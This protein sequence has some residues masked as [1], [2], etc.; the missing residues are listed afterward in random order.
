VR[1][2]LARRPG[3]INMRDSC[4]RT[5]LHRAMFGNRV[6]VVELLLARE[7]TDIAVTNSSNQT[8]LHIGCYMNSVSC[9][10]LYLAHRDCT[11]DLVTRQDIYG[12]TAEMVARDRGYQECAGIVRDYLATVST[13]SSTTSASPTPI[14]E[15]LDLVLVLPDL[16]RELVMLGD[17]GGPTPP[18]ASP[19]PHTARPTPSTARTTPPTARPTTPTARTTPPTARTTPPTARTTPP[20]ATTVHTVST[21]AAPTPSQTML[22]LIPE[23]PVCYDELRPPLEIFTCGTGHLICSVC[24]PDIAGDMCVQRCG[25]RYSG[26][27]TA[28]EQMVR[29]IL[30]I[31]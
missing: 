12:K 18:T 2:I 31:M 7:D 13:P 11:R 3:I 19:T 30:G 16:G 21:P 20:T 10:R 27:A 29:Q 26:R 28:M 8:P 9:V 6:E 22:A 5:G 4:G 1:E 15:S 24:R 25:T 23:C 14:V 17:D